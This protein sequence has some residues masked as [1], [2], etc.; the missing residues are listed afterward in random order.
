MPESGRAE[1]LV[2]GVYPSALHIRWTRPRQTDARPTI[3]SLAVDVEPV[4]F[5]DGVTPSPEALLV[6]WV[7]EV[8]FDERWGNASV[9]HNGSSGA[10]LRDDYL[11]PLGVELVDV[12]YT[13]LIPW[14]FVKTGK[15][16][17][18]DAIAGRYEPWAAEA[19]APAS[20][21]PRRPSPSTL[22][23]LAASEVRRSGLRREILDLRPSAIVTLGQEAID[24]LRAVADRT[25]GGQAVLRPTADY[26]NPGS[27][28]VDAH[29][30][31]VVPVVHPGFLRQRSPGDPWREAHNRWANSSTV[32]RGGTA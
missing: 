15:G 25:D 28:E 23:G 30:F 19:G 24:G 16:S 22:V 13:D 5:W 1:V 20:S 27:V 18:G 21:L 26:G 31:T 29:T 4:V 32:S 12:A 9:G 17:Q 3:A 6:D 2:L 11:S 14:F 7:R 10:G 8:G